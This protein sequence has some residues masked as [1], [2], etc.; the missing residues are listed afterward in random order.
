MRTLFSALVLLLILGAVGW[1]MGWIS[2]GKTE[3]GNTEI[4][5]NNEKLREDIGRGAEKVK[6]ALDNER[7]EAPNS[8]ESAAS[9]GY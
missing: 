1:A 8:A 6:G 4:I 2:F 5:I 9:S 7:P 3:E